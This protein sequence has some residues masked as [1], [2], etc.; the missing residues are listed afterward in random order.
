MRTGATSPPPPLPCREAEE[1]EA[2]SGK[3]RARECGEYRARAGNRYHRVPG[4]GDGQHDTAAR[5]GYQ[6]SPCVRNER[7]VLPCIQPAED[8]LHSSLLVVLMHG[9]ERGLRADVVS[10]YPG[11][12]G[13]LRENAGHRTE[14]L[15]GPCREVAEVA[16]RGADEVEDSHTGR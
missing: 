10:E 12:A 5:V 16:D 6:R 3:P 9:N 7:E 1:G 14:R 2:L 4:I 13:V 8:R 15:G 11:A